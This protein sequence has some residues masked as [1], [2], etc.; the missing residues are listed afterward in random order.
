LS[1]TEGGPRLTDLQGTYWCC[2]SIS[3]PGTPGC[4]DR[5]KEVAL[6]YAFAIAAIEGALPGM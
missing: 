3:T 4:F 2:A 1:I 6:G 5:L